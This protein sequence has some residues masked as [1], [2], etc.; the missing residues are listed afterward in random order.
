MDC[1]WMEASIDTTGADMTVIALLHEFI[2][3]YE[4]LFLERHPPHTYL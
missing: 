1:P 4:R 3:F 2:P